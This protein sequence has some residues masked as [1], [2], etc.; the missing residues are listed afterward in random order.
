MKKTRKK[1]IKEKL[2]LKNKIDWGFCMIKNKLTYSDV[3]NIISR[4]VDNKTNFMFVC[5]YIL[6]D[7]ICHYIKDVYTLEDLTKK[8]SLR[9]DKYYITYYD[10]EFY[11]ECAKVFS[12]NYKLCDLDNIDYFVFNDMPEQTAV[13]KLLGGLIYFCELDN[14]DE[15]C[16]CDCCEEDDEE[17]TDE[18]VE[19]TKILCEYADKIIDAS[20]CPDC[21]FDLVQDLAIKFRDIGFKDSQDL[22]RSFIDDFDE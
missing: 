17:L 12:G 18:E 2:D 13:K 9:T 16:E 6:A 3:E 10:G 15:C 11:C 21:V 22:M 4:H 1:T 7:F 20:P 5:D 19:V 14:E 8:L